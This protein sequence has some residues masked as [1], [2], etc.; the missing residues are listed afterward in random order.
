MKEPGL[1]FIIKTLR[2]EDITGTNTFIS[3]IPIGQVSSG[4]TAEVYFKQ[5]MS[6]NPGFYTLTSG[7]VE[8]TETEM[9]YHDRR[10][11]VKILKIIGKK[12]STG[13]YSMDS[14]VEIT[15]NTN[16]DSDE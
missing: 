10:M 4:S 11:D 8:N 5:K 14:E 2:G 13:Y 3:E 16:K 6:L 15:S 7:V 9:I 12:N 1:G